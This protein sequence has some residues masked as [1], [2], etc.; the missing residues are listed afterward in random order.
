MLTDLASKVSSK[1]SE[2]N[3]FG[4][5]S[6][7]M[8]LENVAATGNLNIGHV[9]NYDA[10][11]ERH[12]AGVMR[13]DENLAIA[14]MASPSALRAGGLPD[15]ALEDVIGRL[16]LPA[17]LAADSAGANGRRPDDGTAL[18]DAPP[19]LMSDI[20]GVPT[21]LENVAGAGLPQAP[22]LP[23]FAG[24]DASAAMEADTK[25]P[26]WLPVG[27][28]LTDTISPEF[29]PVADITDNVG[30]TIDTLIEAVTDA[31]T[32]AV[33]PLAETVSEIVESIEAPVR[34]IAEGIIGNSILP[35]LPAL[36]P[37]VDSTLETVVDIT[38]TATR[39]LAAATESVETVLSP[40]TEPLPDMLA[41]LAAGDA[42]NLVEDTLLMVNGM[43]D[44]VTAVAADVMAATQD[45][46]G[47]VF[48]ALLEA[49]LTDSVDAG[50]EG[51]LD[52]LTNITGL[53][54][55]VANEQTGN[56]LN[57]AGVDDIASVAPD[58]I[59]ASGLID[60][61]SPG[62]TGSGFERGTTT[63]NDPV[64]GDIA[65]L[66]DNNVAVLTDSDTVDLD[67]GIL[68]NNAQQAGDD[69]DIADVGV[70][71]L[72]SNSTQ[73]VQ[74]D[75]IIDLDIGILGENASNAT[76]SDNDLV[77]IDIL[78]R[79]DQAEDNDLID[80]DLLSHTA[81]E[82]NTDLLNSSWL[83]L[84]TQGDNNSTLV[85]GTTEM[86]PDMNPDMLGGILEPGGAVDED[87]DA[88]AV[89]EQVEP[90]QFVDESITMLPELA[91]A[92]ESSLDIVDTLLLDS[93]PEADILPVAEILPVATITS[94]PAV[95][96]L[97]GGLFG[98]GL[99]GNG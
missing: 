24:N 12:L 69:N 25:A 90:T 65:L 72:G 84:D 74:D 2:A 18:A 10:A 21:S 39:L 44:G 5:Q 9:I 16:R 78:S 67:A 80:I 77:D 14:N 20:A 13:L 66:Q 57:V 71:L 43:T 37:V 36:A 99:F 95:E 38:Q 52:M 22:S 30:E 88:T 68:G 51:G 29:L 54:Q 73:A 63:D 82:S 86:L 40:V 59:G 70:A 48:N 75:D 15:V 46:W 89:L 27:E 98:G 45:G 42:G 17:D 26:A 79:S 85:V 92:V 6:L 58:L 7:N 35:E 93:M 76:A 41:S 96:P 8:D 11:S 49:T 1:L 33:T 55:D 87:I 34:G 64:D 81:S 97:T 94:L 47:N 32:D 50:A 60:L 53:A 28:T 3:I 31:A 62:V 61:A 4:G 23:G 56:I 19:F 83:T 91:G